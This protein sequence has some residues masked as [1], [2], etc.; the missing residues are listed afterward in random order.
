MNRDITTIEQLISAFDDAE[1]SE[2]VGILKRINIPVSDFAQYATWKDDSYTRNCVVRHDKFEFILLCWSPG[3][4]TPIHD[5]AGQDCWVYQVDGSIRERRYVQN[6]S[7]FE[8]TNDATLDAGKLCYMHDRMGFHTL[9]NESDQPSMTLHIYA[10]PIDRC[11]VFNED[12]GRFETIEMQYDTIE[13][14]VVLPTG[15]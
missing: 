15:S 7:S 13:G 10:N 5:H 8:T 14:N 3:A 2:Q 12:L 4:I 6:G 1:P 11:Q 9:S